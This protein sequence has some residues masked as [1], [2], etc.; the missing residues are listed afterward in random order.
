VRNLR[1]EKQARQARVPG[2]F[3]PSREPAP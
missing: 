3:S 1:K 2:E